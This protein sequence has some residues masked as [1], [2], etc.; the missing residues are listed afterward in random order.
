MRSPV[1]CRW[2]AFSTDITSV[3][4]GSITGEITNSLVSDDAVTGLKIADFATCSMQESNPGRGDFM[5]NLRWTPSTDAFC[6]CPWVRLRKRK[7]PRGLRG[8]KST[9]CA[10]VVLTTL[11]PTPSSQSQLSAPVK[12]SRAVRLSTTPRRLACTS[13][14]NA[15]NG[16]VQPIEWC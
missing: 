4:A 6:L 5:D 9:T 16:W 7:E 8:L 15:G 10:G 13:F 3:N 14:A 11:I 2:C 1:Y 12:E